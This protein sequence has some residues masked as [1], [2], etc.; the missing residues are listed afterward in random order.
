MRPRRS[1]LMNFALITYQK[2]VL[3]SSLVR[4]IERP[5]LVGGFRDSPGSDDQFRQHKVE[6]SRKTFCT[7]T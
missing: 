3:A 7:N 5:T 4:G 1:A 2:L 6:K